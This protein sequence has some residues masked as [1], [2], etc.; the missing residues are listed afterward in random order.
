MVYLVADIVML[1]GQ[2]G[3]WPI[4]YRAMMKFYVGTVEVHFLITVVWAS[5]PPALIRLHVCLSQTVLLKV[6]NFSAS[7]Q[8]QVTGK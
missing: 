8:V 1:H 3:L 7:L 2:C 6:I 5:V 4:W